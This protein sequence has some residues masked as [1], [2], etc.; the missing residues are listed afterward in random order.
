M[1]DK[2]FL[3]SSSLDEPPENEVTLRD[4]LLLVV[5]H[6]WVVL[7][8]LIVSLLVTGIYTFRQTPVYRGSAVL[9]ISRSDFSLAD[10]KVI[11]NTLTSQEYGTF[12]NTQ[13]KLLKSRTL[14][15]RV[16]DR[17]HLTPRIFLP[18]QQKKQ[19]V[20]Q[21][22]NSARYAE[23]PGFISRISKMIWIFPIQDTHLV[24]IAA[25]TPDPQLSM[26][27]A[28]TWAEEYTDFVLTSN[29]QLTQEAKKLL[30]DQVRSLQREISEKEKILKDV[31]LAQQVIKIDEDKSMSA[32]E[33]DTLNT[34]LSDAKKDRV[35]K[36]V[37]LQ[38]L[39]SQNIE[40]LAEITNYTTVQDVRKE[41]QDIEIEYAQKSKTYKPDYPEIVRLR[42]RLDDARN[43]LKQEMQRTHQKLIAEARRQYEEAVSHE[44]ALTGQLNVSRKAAISVMLKEVSYDQLKQE[45]NKK[46]EVLESL[47]QRQN[48]TGVNA[49]VQEQKATLIRMVDPAELPTSTIRPNI[50]FNFMVG[51]LFGLLMGFGLVFLLE[52][53]DRSLRRPEDVEKYLQV[54]VLGIVPR[55]SPLNGNGRV[56]STKGTVKQPDK[57]SSVEIDLFSFFDSSCV[58]AEAIRT[59]RTSLLLSFP[60][61]APKSVLVTSSKAE[62]GKTFIASNLAIAFAQLQKKVV[63]VDADMRNPRIHRVW[64]IQSNGGLS[65]FLTNPIDIGA[66]I[67]PTQVER[68]SVITCGPRSPR[69]AEL[70]ASTR[71]DELLKQLGEQFDVVL[72]DSPPLM[73]VTD[74]V[75]LASK[76]Q[77]VMLVIHGGSTPREFVQAAK[78]KL[79]KADAPV[80]G[81][82]LNNI[83]F[84]D[85]YYQ[86][87]YY[88]SYY[89][90]RYEDSDQKALPESG[91]SQS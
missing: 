41:L 21:K 32:D 43:K 33:L 88:Y 12:F 62:E 83:D 82:V 80:V 19:L 36:Q 46:K 57:V 55:Y 48:E 26:K 5:K 18:P 29:Y 74:S 10:D 2:T 73:P 40:A 70:L 58:A 15:R 69:P 4:Y 3:P 25:D 42:E 30:E 6:R 51:S 85:P 52:H 44:Q 38:Q 11:S 50:P 89:K 17:L 72:V 84:N 60:G 63:L 49:E 22:D 45:I 28:N 68:V 59:L 79:G 14:T 54:P 23:N 86:Y 77:S 66:V 27:L 76:C 67:A 78:K 13:Y 34:S 35:A 16:I 81:V 71:F 8:T 56:L 39:R 1:K 64:N 24:E 87:S 31:S 20:N 75:I 9:F 91:V 61:S 47:L 65:R 90:Y 53:L 7:V 37:Y